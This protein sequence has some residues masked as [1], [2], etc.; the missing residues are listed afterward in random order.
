[1]RQKILFSLLL[2]PLLLAI[3]GLFIDAYLFVPY[4]R[5]T[6]QIAY[7]HI[8]DI[9]HP[10]HEDYLLLQKVLKKGKRPELT[11]LSDMRS[12]C[13]KLQLVEKTAPP[14]SGV[15]HVNCTGEEKENCL[16]VYASLN[17]NFKG[18]LK[19]LI[20]HVQASD[21]RGDILYRIGGWPNTAEGDLVVAHVPYAFK[22]SFLRK[23]KRLGY[24]RALWLDTSIIPLVSLNTIF[25]QI[26]E[27]GYF[28]M[29]NEHMV[30]PYF[31]ESAAQT[32]GVSF[33]ETFNIPS[34]SAGLFG[35]DFSTS[36]VTQVLDDL[37][38]AAKETQA[39][40]SARSDQ[41]VLSVLMYKAGMR[42]WPLI[43]TAMAERADQITPNTLFLIDRNFVHH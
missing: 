19:R 27:Q 35:L 15:I 12:R 13:L 21:Y 20:D 18:G 23:A 9:R 30:G 31:N 24:K 41:N 32:L 40:F 6:P 16:V 10:S 37:Y 7:Q 8:K 29:G 42:N 22:V 4:T 34:C 39:F 43:Q 36:Q 5:W 26:Q 25:R 2:G 11:L 1:M 17:K 28:L 38:R 3:T 33:G 14:E